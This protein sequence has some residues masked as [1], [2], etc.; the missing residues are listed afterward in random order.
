MKSSGDE[1]VLI[2]GHLESGTSVQRNPL[3]FLMS[4]GLV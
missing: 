3:Y 1:E 4:H 2:S